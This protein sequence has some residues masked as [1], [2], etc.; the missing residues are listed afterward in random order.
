MT[1]RISLAPLRC[2]LAMLACAGAFSANAALFEDDEARKA[3]LDLRQRVESNRQAAEAADAGLL[4]QV[5]DVK[6]IGEENN[7]LLRRSLLDLSNQIE[8]LRAEIA[9]LRGQ[10]EQLV[11]DISELQS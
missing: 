4:K 2:A 6:R 5:E 9:R 8:A 1:M 10:D 7:A 11:R 3:I